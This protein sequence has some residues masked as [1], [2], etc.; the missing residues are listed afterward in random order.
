[1]Y[2]LP[3]TIDY[4][5][6][7]TGASQIYYVGHSQG[8]E[9]AFSGFGMDWNHADKVKMFFALAPVTYLGHMKSPVRVLVPFVE[10][11]E[12]CLNMNQLRYAT[13]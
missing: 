1:M 12:V 3:A 2:D 11:I 10:P 6:A 7:E 5:L 4:I 8:T 13:L 9:I